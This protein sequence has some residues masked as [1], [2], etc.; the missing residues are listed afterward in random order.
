MLMMSPL[1]AAVLV[2]TMR[3]PGAQARG[4]DGVG[5]AVADAD[6][7]APRMAAIGIEDEGDVPPPLSSQ[8]PTGASS[9]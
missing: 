5:I 2:V 8:P 6:G 4:F 1:T 9:A 7:G 3:L